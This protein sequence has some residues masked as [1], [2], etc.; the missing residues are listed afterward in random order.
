MALCTPAEVEAM[1]ALTPSL[2]NLP[3]QTS[4]DTLVQTAIDRADAWMQGHMGANYNLTQFTWQPT[5]QKEGQIY[6]ALE[7]L[8]DLLKAQKIYGTHFPYMSE[9]SPAY[10]AL[11][12]NEWGVRGMAALDLWVTIESATR[13]F[14]L[15]LLLTSS[16]LIENDVL[17]PGLDPL[18]VQYAEL[19]DRARGLGVPDVGS[20]RR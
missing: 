13:H 20:V 3:D 12:D 17:N 1:G 2:F 5:L 6:L 8:C 19:L 7:K 9:D 14:A 16:P 11:I 18:A 10:E 4:L 15:P